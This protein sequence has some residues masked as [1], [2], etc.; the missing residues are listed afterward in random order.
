LADC[1]RWWRWY[2][3]HVQ[4]LGGTRLF[5]DTTTHSPARSTT[6]LVLPARVLLPPLATSFAGIHGRPAGGEGGEDGEA[7]AA[8]GEG[9]EAEER[10]A[11]DGK[12]TCSE[13]LQEARPAS[14][15]VP[16]G[17]AEHEVCPRS[18]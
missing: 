17:H 14:E 11:P 3:A 12:T 10:E 18:S 7:A 4:P 5:T 1:K 9:G 13:V 6:R 2:S 16:V 15:Y 8:G